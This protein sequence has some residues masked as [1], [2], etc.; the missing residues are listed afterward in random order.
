MTFRQELENALA[1]WAADC[2]EAYAA[3]QT[4]FDGVIA[5]LRRRFPA[6]KRHEID[7]LLGDARRETEQLL[8]E[9][10]TGSVDV[11]AVVD[12]CVRF[13]GED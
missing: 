8:D 9:L 4:I 10:I 11:G 7:L 6:I 5:A 1:S 3:T 2:G 12:V 13:T